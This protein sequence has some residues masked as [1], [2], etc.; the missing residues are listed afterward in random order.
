MK[1]ENPD[2]L[3]TQLITYIGNKRALLPFIGQGV[4]IVRQKLNKD[5][6]NCL[7]IFAG[8]GIVARY[9]KQFS[10][11]ITVN[12]LES[13]ACR[14]SRC[15]LSNKSNIN[16]EELDTFYT[17]LCEKIEKKMSE[18]EES[19]KNG[20]YKHPGF[21]SELYSPN[22]LNNIQK[23]E[24]CF[25][26]PYNANYLDVTRQLIDTEI[27][28]EYQDFFIAPLLSEASIHANTAGIFKGFYKNSKTGIGQFGGNGKNALSRITGNISLPFPVLSE[29]ECESKIFNKDANQLVLEDKT[30]YDLAY[31]DPPYNQHAYGSNYFML[32][33]ISSYQ[34]PDEEFISRVS[35]I[36]KGWNR[37]VYNKKKKV[38]QA[39]SELVKNVNAR[40]VLISFNSE[41][42][43]S[44]EEM[45]LLL[46]SYGKV[47]VLESKYNTFRGSR[48]LGNRDIHVKEYLFL[49]EKL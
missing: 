32:N 10:S 33:L 31:F 15:Y 12:D 38:A 43:I 8:S 37:S 2:F 4:E 27:P 25:Y 6:L 24:R 41:G 45:I 47:E 1:D 42:Y 49:L 18:I 28:E 44:K 34:R 5:K 29:F 7:D 30:M 14:I 17:K 21:I 26:T 35:G 40:F 39:F 3:Q 36:P 9:L 16:I 22:D 19:R 11:S 20:T 48:N 23:A 13:Y 46:E